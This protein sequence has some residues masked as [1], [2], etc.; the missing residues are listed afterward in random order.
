M[1]EKEVSDLTE[2]LS[3]L[4]R[5]KEG[6]RVRGIDEGVEASQERETITQ[7]S[8]RSPSPGKTQRICGFQSLSSQLYGRC[9]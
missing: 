6:E 7:E 1:Q 2:R 4:E 3:E 9:G 8:A 5:Q